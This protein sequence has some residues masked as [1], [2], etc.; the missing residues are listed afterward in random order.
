MLM[1]EIRSILSCCE[2]EGDGGEAEDR[3]G[4]RKHLHSFGFY[5]YRK[6]MVSGEMADVD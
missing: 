5:W 1:V 3:E 2:D 6:L 4:R